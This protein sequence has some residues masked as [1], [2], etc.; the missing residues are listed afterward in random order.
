M[1]Y[2]NTGSG[3]GGVITETDPIYTADKPN[4]ALKTDLD[5]KADKVVITE[6]TYLSNGKI[7]TQ[8]V[9]GVLKTAVYVNGVLDSWQ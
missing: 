4:I 8:K 2:K 7:N 3:G 6:R 5:G 1:I 9:N